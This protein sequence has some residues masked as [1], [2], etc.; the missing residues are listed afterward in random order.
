MGEKLKKWIWILA[1]FV[2]LTGTPLVL[3][4]SSFFGIDNIRCKTQYGPCEEADDGKLKEF[5]GQNLFLLMSQS[6]ESLMK[7]DFQT[8]NVSVQKV[9]PKK[10]V[11]VLDKRKP[12][13]ALTKEGLENGMFLLD[14]DGVVIGVTDKSSL[15]TLRLW[16][17]TNLVVGEKVDPKINQ[18]GELL[19]IT[20]RALSAESGEYKNLKDDFFVVS[21]PN[22]VKVYYS[23]GRDPRVL[24]GALQLI[25]TR[26][27]IDGKMPISIDLRY[28]NPVLRY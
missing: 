3:L 12:L 17:D 9:F 1:I 26:S 21:I 22:S 10:L 16:K 14:Q 11:V 27:R 2:F 25:L 7:Q 13:V 6:V 4:R 8:R 24:I 23:L 20:N 18:A 28:S 5:Y 15:P 19:F